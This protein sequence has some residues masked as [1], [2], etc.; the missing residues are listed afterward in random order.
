MIRR[1]QHI[2]P[3]YIVASKDKGEAHAPIQQVVCNF[4][5][6]MGLGPLFGRHTGS[7]PYKITQRQINPS[8]IEKRSTNVQLVGAIHRPLNL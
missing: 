5:S 3:E 8:S 2:A 7:C 1:S 4:M 6:I